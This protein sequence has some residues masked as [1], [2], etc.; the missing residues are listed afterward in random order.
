MITKRNRKSQDGKRKWTEFRT[1]M[2]LVEKG[3]EDEGKKKFWVTVAFDEDLDIKEL[4]RGLLTV[5]VADISFPKVYEI[6]TTEDG[7]KQYPKVW[8]N[9]YKEFSPVEKEVENPFVTDEVETEETTF[10]SDEELST[11][12]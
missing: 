10:D 1:P 4:G 2:M 8:V 11:E 7:K 3:K 6:K 12:D 5:K 9:N